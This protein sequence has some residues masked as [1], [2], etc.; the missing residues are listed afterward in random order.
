MLLSTSIADKDVE[1]PEGSDGV[2]DQIGVPNTRML[3]A[4]TALRI[5]GHA[6]PCPRPMSRPA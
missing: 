2:H 3:A 5:S 1:A 6:S 4:W